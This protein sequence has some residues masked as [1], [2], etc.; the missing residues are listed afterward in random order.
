M[1]LRVV[2]CLL[3]V[4]ALVLLGGCETPLAR[5]HDHPAA[6][7]KLSAADQRLVLFGEVH[8]G[9]SAD[10]V[11]IAWGGPDEKRTTGSG[12]E[13]AESWLYHRQLTVKARR[14][15]RSTNGRWAPAFL[16]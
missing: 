2:Y 11:Y 3:C 12:K 14:W 8:P 7:G 9:M 1:T 4:A 13:A 15:V 10:A 5:A 6:F 16:G